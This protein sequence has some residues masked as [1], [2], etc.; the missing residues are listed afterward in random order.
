MNQGF[1]NL[2]ANSTNFL[3]KIKRINLGEG[4]WNGLGVYILVI[5][6]LNSMLTLREVGDLKNCWR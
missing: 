4:L 1:E 2:I 5:T 3:P 6:L